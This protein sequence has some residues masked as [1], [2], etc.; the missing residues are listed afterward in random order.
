MSAATG[1]VATEALAALI[2][3]VSRDVG[4]QPMR[5]KRTAGDAGL[6]VGSAAGEVRELRKEMRERHEEMMEV[7]ERIAG[8]AVVQPMMSGGLG[9]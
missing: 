5:K 4:T 3:F 7:L 8:G 2:T 1:K 6:D 9:H